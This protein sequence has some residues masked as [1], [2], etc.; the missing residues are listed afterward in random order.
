MVPTMVDGGG[1]RVDIGYKGLS[2]L[3]IIFGCGD[4]A[5]RSGDLYD[6]GIV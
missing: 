5:A 6:V 1:E 3:S 4:C 2:H